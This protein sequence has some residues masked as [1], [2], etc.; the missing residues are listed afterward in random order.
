MS[1]AYD[2]YIADDRASSVDYIDPQK[3]YE[4]AY[5]AEMRA[6][7]GHLIDLIESA[8]K[9]EDI[10][11]QAASLIAD[12]RRAASDAYRDAEANNAM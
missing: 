5:D 11:V 3:A 10:R 2:R 8:A 4:D 9:G 12:A 7:I 1:T 6:D